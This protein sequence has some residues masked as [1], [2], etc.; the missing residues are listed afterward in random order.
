MFVERAVDWYDSGITPTLIYELNQLK[1]MRMA[2]Q[3]WDAVEAK[4][5][6][7][8]WRKSGIL[9]QAI[10]PLEDTEPVIKIEDLLSDSLDS[11]VATGALQ[12]ANVMSIEF[13][14]NPPDEHGSMH[15]PIT[16][17]EIYQEVL[18]SQEVEGITIVDDDELDQEEQPSRREALNAMATLQ[19]FAITMD[20][21][22]ARKLE[23]ILGSFGRQMRLEEAKGLVDNKITQYFARE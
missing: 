14:L 22:V 18:Q 3:A 5:I 13:L 16:D 8:C 2:A 23:G 6:A 10:M 11:L 4:T 17:E 21:P 9:P 12:Q 7:N 19:R 15:A 1:A 20:D